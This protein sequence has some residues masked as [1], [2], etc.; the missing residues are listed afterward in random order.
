MAVPAALSGAYALEPPGI[1]VVLQEDCHAVEG[2]DE[3]GEPKNNWGDEVNSFERD[4]D[5]VVAAKLWGEPDP[6]LYL[7]DDDG[8]QA[9]ENLK[10][11]EKKKTRLSNNAY[12]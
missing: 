2:G 4:V 9:M 11:Q 6:C 7:F 3:E 8:V 12:L 10:D 5:D 1:E